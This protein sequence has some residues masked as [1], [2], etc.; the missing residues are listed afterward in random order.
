[1]GLETGNGGGVI[2]CV[3]C[4][5][6]RVCFCDDAV[7]I[8]G[9]LGDPWG[10]VRATEEAED[11]TD[12]TGFW[13]RGTGNVSRGRRVRMRMGCRRVERLDDCGSGRRVRS[14]GCGRSEDGVGILS[15]S[16]GRKD[17]MSLPSAPLYSSPDQLITS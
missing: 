9:R 4:D 13:M 6:H 3:E 8:L 11:W 10:V 12:R 5:E 7:D 16:K 15:S 1:M 2:R 14:C 17:W